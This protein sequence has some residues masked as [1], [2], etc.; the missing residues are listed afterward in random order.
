M[1]KDGLKRYQIDPVAVEVKPVDKQELAGLRKIYETQAEIAFAMAGT[2]QTYTPGH[3][4]LG[5]A[6]TALGLPDIRTNEGLIAYKEI[7]EAKRREAEQAPR[8]SRER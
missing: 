4:K 7:L 6:I 1:A 2:E 5:I 8:S 3:P